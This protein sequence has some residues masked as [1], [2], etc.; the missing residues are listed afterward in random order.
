M[1]VGVLVTS[2]RPVPASSHAYN[3]FL[4][5]LR[6]LGYVEGQNVIIEWRNYEGSRERRRHEAAQLVAWKPDVVFTNN[7][8]SA[9]ALQEVDA[10]IPIVV[11]AGGD[12][13]SIG[14]TDSLARPRGNVTGLQVLQIE[15]APKRLQILKELMPRLQRVALL[16]QTPSRAEEIGSSAQ[17]FTALDTAAQTLSVRI[18]RF[19]AASDDEFDR[20]FANMK[21]DAEAVMVFSNPFMAVQRRRLAE[22]AAHHRLPTMHDSSSYVEA[23][24]W[25]RTARRCP[26]CTGEPPSMWIRFS[27]ARSPVT[28]LLSSPRRSNWWSTSRP[29]R[30]SASR[31]RSRCWGGRTR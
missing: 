21:R 13:V 26:T 8:T 10:S 7:G 11:A 6:N 1:A 31:S 16:H 17:L 27:R 12:L 9:L 25:L 22:L 29:R 24:G 28:C 23:G 30:R 15:L 20:V 2:P 4:N 3:S 18:H 5:E 19:T 14:L